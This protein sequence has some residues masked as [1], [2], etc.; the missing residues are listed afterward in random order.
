MSVTPTQVEEH[1]EHRAQQFVE[2]I[3]GKLVRMRHHQTLFFALKDALIYMVNYCAP[4]LRKVLRKYH[5]WEEFCAMIHVSMNKARGSLTGAD[6][7][8]LERF[9]KTLQGVSKQRIRRLFSSQPSHRDFEQALA[10]ECEKKYSR[11]SQRDRSEH[12]A[13]I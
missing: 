11:D 2:G 10:T 3:V 12:Y 13:L 6:D 7:R 5:G 9:E 8:D 1:G 4:T